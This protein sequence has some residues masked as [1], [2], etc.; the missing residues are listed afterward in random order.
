MPNR[1]RQCKRP[2]GMYQLYPLSNRTR[3]RKASKEI[4]RKGLPTK[5][6][7]H[8]TR[9]QLPTTT[10]QKTNMLYIPTHLL[11]PRQRNSNVQDP[12]TLQCKDTTL[13]H[14]RRRT[15]TKTKHAIQ[16]Q[17]T[18]LLRVTKRLQPPTRQKP[19]TR[20]R[21]TIRRLRYGRLPTREKRQMCK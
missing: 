5:D 2:R 7:N 20:K 13:T 3:R 21:S 12:S 19:Y 14:C 1:Q 18:S 4:R 15:N 17:T 11:N 10:C 6:A 9:A 16:S 8:A